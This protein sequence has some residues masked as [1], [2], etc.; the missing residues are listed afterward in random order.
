MELRFVAGLIMDC[1]C[2]PSEGLGR[3]PGPPPD[4]S[5]LFDIGSLAPL[6]AECEADLAAF[7]MLDSG[8]DGRQ[9]PDPNTPLARQWVLMAAMVTATLLLLTLSATAALICLQ[10][11]LVW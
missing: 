4:P 6:R 7:G 11:Y 10:R 1:D 2:G 9:M 5:F 8:S 3:L